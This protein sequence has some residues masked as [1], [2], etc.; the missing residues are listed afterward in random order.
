[1]DEH[2]VEQLVSMGFPPSACRKAVYLTGNKGA[3]VA[4]EWLMTHLEDVD[5]ANEH[6]DL[7]KKNTNT[8]TSRQENELISLGFTAHQARYALR[9]TNGEVNGAAEWLFSSAD[10]VPPMEEESPS[11]VKSTMRNGSGRYRLVG[12]ISHMGTSVHSGH[13]VA[14]LFKEGRWVLFNDEKVAVSQHPPRSMAYIYLFR[15]V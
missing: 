12:F 9:L 15:R 13:Y 8:E 14:H 4:S 10:L 3:E 1:L 11:M 7:I 6:P 2:A 5:F